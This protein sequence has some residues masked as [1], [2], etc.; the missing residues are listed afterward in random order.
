MR[1]GKA[2]IK[3]L[4]VPI[5]E[6]YKVGP[7]QQLEIHVKTLSKNLSLAPRIYYIV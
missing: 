5:L 1:L 4:N 2:V 3:D 6:D 7:N